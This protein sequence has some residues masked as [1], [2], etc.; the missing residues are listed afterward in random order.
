MIFKICRECLELNNRKTKDPIKLDKGLELSKDGQIGNKNIKICSVAQKVMWGMLLKMLRYMYHTIP[1][2]VPTIKTNNNKLSKWHALV[3]RRILPNV[4]RYRTQNNRATIT[5]SKSMT[6]P[7]D[8]VELPYALAS[9]FLLS[10]QLKKLTYKRN[11]SFNISHYSGRSNPRSGAH[12]A[13][14]L[15]WVFSMVESKLFT[16]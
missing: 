9:C 14:S 4:K 6:V 13:L 8:N 12:I 3:R 15:W 7:K 2:K 1:G 11:A 16:S 10:K 5:A